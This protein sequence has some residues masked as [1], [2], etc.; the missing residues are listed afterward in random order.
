MRWPFFSRTESSIRP[1]KGSDSDNIAVLH[2]EGGFSGSWSTAEIESLIADQAVVTEVACDSR[3]SGHLF[4]FLM[5]RIAADEAEILTIAVRIKSR[6]KG[7][8]R[9]LMDMHMARLAGFGVKT[10]YLEVEEDNKPARAL[11][12]KMGFVT[13]GVR[14]GYYRKSDGNFANALIM[15]L[16]LDRL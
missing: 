5:S 4:G 13:A 3:I 2:A 16:G 11:Y 14:K 6:G 7:I 1:A 9:R 12:G 10:L 8:G 15:K